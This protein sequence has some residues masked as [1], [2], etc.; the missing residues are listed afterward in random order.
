MS[1]G[2]ASVIERQLEL[3][4]EGLALLVRQNAFYRRKLSRVPLPLHSMDDYRRLPFTSK[5]EL[6]EDQTATPP[7]GTNLT[8]PASAYTR[9]HSTSGTTGRKLKV[10]DTEESWAWFTRCWQQIYRTFGVGPGDRV[11]AAFGFGPFVG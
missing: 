9:L 8:Y 1:E 7:Y 2:R 11:F 5:N 4:N 3:L 6:V 10:L